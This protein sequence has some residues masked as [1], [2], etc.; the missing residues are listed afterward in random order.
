M[1][2]PC[3]IALSQELVS[4]ESGKEKYAVVQHHQTGEL[5][6]VSSDRTGELRAGPL[7][8]L[9]ASSSEPFETCA[10]AGRLPAGVN[11]VTIATGQGQ[12]YAAQL[13]V[14]AWLGIVHWGNVDLPYKVTYRSWD[15]TVAGHESGEL[16]RTAR[17]S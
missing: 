15:G 14:G 16:V 10:I 4:A 6:L 8:E 12:V 2:V 11:E 5:W 17:K 3:D 9:Q 7:G 13:G 1:S